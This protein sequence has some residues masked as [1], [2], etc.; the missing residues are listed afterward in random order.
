M[1]EVEELVPRTLGDFAPEKRQEVV[2]IEVGLESFVARF[3]PLQEAL[4]RVRVAG[5]GQQVGNQS[6]LAK[7]SLR[8]VPGLMVPGHFTSIGARKPPSK[9]VPRPLRRLGQLFLRLFPLY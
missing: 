9:V 2:A 3:H 5:G 4:F 1:S 6:S 8:I 7:I